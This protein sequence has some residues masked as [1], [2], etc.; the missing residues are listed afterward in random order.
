[1][2]AAGYFQ[3][4]QEIAAHR[5]STPRLNRS[6]HLLNWR[7]ASAPAQHRVHRLPRLVRGA[8]GDVGAELLASRRYYWAHFSQS[9]FW[10]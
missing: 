9:V 7:H 6:E 4:G 8:D 10:P 2:V 5:P 3:D 1:M